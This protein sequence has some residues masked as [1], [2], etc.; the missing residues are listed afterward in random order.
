[1]LGFGAKLVLRAI[2]GRFRKSAVTFLGVALAVASLV[3]LEAIMEGVSDTMVRNSVS[4]HHGHVLASW[5][6]GGKGGGVLL[7]AGEPDM[8]HR[9]RLEGTCVVGSR[10]ISTVLYGVIPQA[11]A[12][13]TVIASP[14]AIGPVSAPAVSNSL[15]FASVA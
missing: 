14:R 6:A 7:F 13:R 4:L 15:M 12:R 10:Q 3:T 11:E 2:C 5:P 1:M 8:L 9:E